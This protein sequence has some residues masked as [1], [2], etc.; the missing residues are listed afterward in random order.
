MRNRLLSPELPET[1]AAELLQDIVEGLYGDDSFFISHFSDDLSLH[2]LYDLDPG[3]ENEEDPLADSVDEFFPESLILAAENPVPRVSPIDLT[4]SAPPS[5]SMPQLTPQDMDLRCYEEMPPVSDEEDNCSAEGIT[6]TM[7]KNAI[8]VLEE[9]AASEES[10]KLDN[11]EVPGHGCKS[12]QYHRAKSGEE[13]VLCSLCYLRLN[14][15]FV[16]SKFLT[17][18]SLGGNKWCCCL[19]TGCFYRRSCFGR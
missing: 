11:P 10:F 19:L 13:E 16:Y 3:N 17:L 14:A 7:V 2:D 1:V 18:G 6:K 5:G 15:A 12:C 8:Q 4:I 9:E